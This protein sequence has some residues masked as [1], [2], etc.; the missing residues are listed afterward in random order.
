MPRQS[1]K[2][3]KKDDEERDIGKN[4]NDKGNDND[5]KNKMTERIM[6]KR[7]KILNTSLRV[8]KRYAFLCSRQRMRII[9]LYQE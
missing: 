7:G 2:R 6:G 9:E 8:V 3:N 5:G 1:I 4:D